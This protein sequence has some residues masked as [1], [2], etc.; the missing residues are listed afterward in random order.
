MRVEVLDE[1]VELLGK[2]GGADGLACSHV[3]LISQEDT[4]LLSLGLVAVGRMPQQLLAQDEVGE[5]LVG[6]LLELSPEE[7]DKALDQPALVPDC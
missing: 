3:L 2:G 1:A 5:L 4:V 7:L 6:G